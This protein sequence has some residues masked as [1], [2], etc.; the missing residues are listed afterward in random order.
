[1]GAY[2]R[3]RRSVTDERS[4]IIMVPAPLGSADV[5]SANDTRYTAKRL[6]KIFSGSLVPPTNT[7]AVDR[8]LPRPNCQHKVSK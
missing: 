1:V 7:A 2:T 6:C 3:Y 5:M 8:K 4:L